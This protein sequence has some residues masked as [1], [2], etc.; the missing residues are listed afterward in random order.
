MR[1]TPG[2][3]FP[4]L[5]I[6]SSRV[7]RLTKA[8]A[9]SNGVADVSQTVVFANGPSTQSGKSA[10]AKEARDRQ[11]RASRVA[12]WYVET[13]IRRLSTGRDPARLK[14]LYHSPGGMKWSSLFFPEN[15][16]R[17]KSLFTGCERLCENERK[18]VRTRER[19]R[20]PSLHGINVVDVLHGQ[21][22]ELRS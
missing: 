14:Y 21:Q 17:Q 9:R 4:V 6:F 18:P 19:A 8:L 15:T 10:Y 1:G 20:H 11:A 13:N 22:V 5:L 12:M 7:K 3:V 16:A 2:D